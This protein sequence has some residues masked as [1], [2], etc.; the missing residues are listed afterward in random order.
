MKA[1]VE[2]GFLVTLGKND[3]WLQQRAEYIL[4][5]RDVVTSLF[6]YLEMHC[7]GAP[8]V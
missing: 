4:N 3:D 8:L 2:T 7:P 5:E 6:A 1:F